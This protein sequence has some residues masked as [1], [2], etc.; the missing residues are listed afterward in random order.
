MK[1]FFRSVVSAYDKLLAVTVFAALI[2]SLLYLAVKL[3]TDKSKQREW[4]RQVS[5]MVPAYEE[6]STVSNESFDAAIKGI[7]TPFQIDFTNWSFALVVPERRVTCVDCRQPIPY[8]VEECP[9]CHTKQPE[10][11]ELPEGFDGDGDGMDDNW[12]RK[13]GLDPTDP[14]DA[15]TDLDGDGFS[16]LM[17]FLHGTDPTDSNSFPPHEAWIFVASIESD[18]FRLLFRG[19]S[20]GP[21]GANI[22]QIN[23]RAGN[24]PRTFFKKIGED[25]EGFK[26]VDFQT[27]FV[28]KSLGPGMEMNVDESIL[29]VQRAD[30]S[31]RLTKGKDVEFFELNANLYFEI[32]KKEFR[33]KKDDTFELRGNKYLV[34]QVDM[35]KYHVVIT[36]VSD[37]KDFVLTRKVSTDLSKPDVG[38]GQ[39]GTS[40]Q[41]VN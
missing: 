19:V 27:N 34:K 7:E 28:K 4:E 26:V 3:G 20:V 25:V 14:G 41:T 22:F 2:V 9:I 18:P 39:I 40:A 1:N 6:A 16:N 5:A 11:G 15:H 35:D 24:P 33:V 23:T 8:D 32:E 38:S 30:K 12:E 37:S 13:Y 10:D 36:R 17:E 31:I 29:T 21:D